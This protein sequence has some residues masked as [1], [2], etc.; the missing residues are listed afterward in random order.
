MPGEMGE[1]IKVLALGKGKVTV[2]E[3]MTGR[4]MRTSL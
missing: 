1:S 4:D 3:G 2:P